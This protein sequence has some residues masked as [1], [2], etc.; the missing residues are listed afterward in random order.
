MVVDRRLVDP[1]PLADALHAEPTRPELDEDVV[2]R[3]HQRVGAR[4]GVDQAR[5]VPSRALLAD[6]W[7]ST[8]EA[9]HRH[10]LTGWNTF[11]VDGPV[12]QTK[13]RWTGPST[14]KMAPCP[15]GR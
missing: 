8:A 9:V 2:D 10:R 3:P 1:T 4:L 13:V 6:S 12:Q 5:H 14:R 11:R 7:R 15:Q